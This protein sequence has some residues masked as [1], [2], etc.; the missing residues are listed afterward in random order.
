[1]SL[2]KHNIDFFDDSS[3]ILDYEYSRFRSSLLIHADCMEWL[4]RCPEES[5]QAVVTDPP[6]GVKEYDFDQIEKRE[7]GNGGVWRIPPSFDGSNR[8]PLPRFTALSER[9]RQR[10]HKFFVEWSKL[11]VRAC[12][13]G[14]HIFVASNSFL[15]QLMFDAIIEGGLEY[16]GNVIRLVSTFRGGDRPKNFEKEFPE[17]CS[18]PRGSYEPW[19][20]FRKPLPKK[21]TVAE[22]LR[23]YKTGALRRISE[24]KPFLDVIE[25]ERTPAEEKAIAD[26]P[27]LKPQSFMRQIVR[28]SLPLG[29]GVILDPFM[30][31]G[32]TIAAAEAVG[33]SAIGVERFKDYFDLS[34]NSIN[35]LYEIK[36]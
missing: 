29:E 28:T 11:V 18:L 23:T 32:S 25:S 1:M 35:Q 30:G 9:E 20:I 21:M 34:L 7:N 36:K 8:S 22:C 6:Y 27:S 19:G 33:Y 5:I 31:S 3:L 16:R 12:V 13:P 17:V 24:N 26:H 2:R 4:S 14:A 10:I 15:S